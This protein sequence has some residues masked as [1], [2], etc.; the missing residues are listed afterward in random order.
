LCRRRRPPGNGDG[1]LHASSDGDVAASSARVDRRF[2]TGRAA[3]VALGGGGPLPA[4]AI[5]ARSGRRRARF[6]SVAAAG[7]PSDGE[8]F[9]ALP[10]AA[11]LGVSAG[12]RTTWISGGGVRALAALDRGRGPR[13]RHRSRAPRRPASISSSTTE[14]ERCLGLEMCNP[15][16]VQRR[17]RSSDALR[18]PSP[19][20]SFPAKGTRD[21]FAHL[22]PR[23]RTQTT[24]ASDALGERETAAALPLCAT[25]LY[26]YEA[27]FQM[28]HGMLLETVFLH[29]GTLVRDI[30]CMEHVLYECINAKKTCT[31]I[32]KY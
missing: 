3:A 14:Q 8:P 21:Y 30:P 32:I 28:R 11:G 4:T 13:R 12:T 10:A 5:R 16:G 24:T 19:A 6:R 29:Y 23:P 7:L 18:P 31:C 1:F 9:R 25:G 2:L 20:T 27:F 17:A 22:L 26:A 15:A